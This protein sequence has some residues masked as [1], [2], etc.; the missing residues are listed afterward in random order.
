MRNRFLAALILATFSTGAVAVQP[1][2]SI[3]DTHTLLL[4]S[5]GT[6]WAWGSNSSYQLGID[7]GSTGTP[8]QVP[9]FTGVVDVVAKP[10]GFSMAL[11]ADGTVWVWGNVSSG[12][13][14]DCVSC[15]GNFVSVPYK[16][17]SVQQMVSIAA[18]SN[19]YTV[20]AVDSVGQAWS[21]GEGGSGELGDGLTTDRATPQKISGVTNVAS[22]S[23]SNQAVMALRS[24]GSLMGWGY[25]GNGSTQDNML[26]GKLGANIITPTVLNVPSVVSADAIH[27][28][29]SGQFFGLTTAG[30]P[31]IWGDTNS[32]LI[33]CNQLAGG[34]NIIQPYTPTGLSGIRQIAGGD[35]YALFL[36]Q[37]GQVLGCGGNTHGELGDGT[38][39]STGF[40]NVP[41]KPGPVMTGGLP[42]SLLSIAAGT[43][44]SAALDTLGGVYTWGRA[45]GGLSGQGDGT[46]PTVNTTA[47]KLSINAGAAASAPA[48]FSGTQSGPLSN[49]TVDVGIAVAPAHVGQTGQVYIAIVLPDSTGTI[50]LLNSSGAFV[51]YSPGSPITARYSGLLPKIL[52]LNLVR[53][54]NLTSFSGTSVIMG[55][56]LGSGTAADADM[57]SNGRLSS[58]LQ[59]Q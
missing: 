33:N 32:G 38:L 24:D 20:L 3:G 26:A 22:I 15:G 29:T 59:L 37:N 14:A 30:T 23:A 35:S 10:G 55:Y 31:L 43:Y 2:I 9:N 21:W 48:I 18:T 19:G 56:G 57:L 52:P 41:T 54:T 34:T 46:S 12:Q 28:N 25:N 51:P 13:A 27:M 39:I 5:D 36:N 42:T 58:L 44:S 50:L 16:V 7:G 47:V 1:K 49:A 17:P 53:D 40:S 6:V 11:K 4:K 45:S 8:T